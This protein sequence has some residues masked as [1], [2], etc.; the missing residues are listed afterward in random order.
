MVL[1]RGLEAI[2]D[3]CISGETVVWD[4]EAEAESSRDDDASVVDDPA[5]DA[6]VHCLFLRWQ[7]VHCGV[8]PEQRTFM[9][10]HS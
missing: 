8:S 2:L 6:Y 4:V 7:L 3:R 1:D 9:A 10:L 5:F